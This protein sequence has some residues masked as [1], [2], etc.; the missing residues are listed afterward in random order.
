VIV[1]KV[2]NSDRLALRDRRGVISYDIVETAQ[3]Y[4]R[5]LAQ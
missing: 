2:D 1:V 5:E 3:N 4:R